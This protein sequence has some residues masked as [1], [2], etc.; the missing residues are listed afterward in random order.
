VLNFDATSASIPDARTVAFSQLQIYEHGNLASGTV[1][2]EGTT[3][4]GTGTYTVAA[5]TYTRVGRMVFVQMTIIWTAHTGTGNI[6]IT[7]LPFT[8]LTGGNRLSTLNVIASNLA[9]TSGNYLAAAPEAT[10]KSM[11]LYQV[12]ASA[13]LSGV[14]I[15]TAATLY[16]SG[17]YQAG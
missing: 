15:D 5:G 11:L 6:R 13:A 16:I 7:G 4:A 9:Y 8:V 3:S 14:P 2:I 10:T 17:V 1:T 12:S